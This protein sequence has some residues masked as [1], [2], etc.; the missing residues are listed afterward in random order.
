MIRHRSLHTL[1]SCILFLVAGIGSINLSYSSSLA[2]FEN[3]ASKTNADHR[4]VGKI[5]SAIDN[6]F[7]TVAELENAIET[8]NYLLIGEKHDN[9]DHHRL[10]RL[11]VDFRLNRVRTTLP[12]AV[13]LEMLDRKQLDGVN[14]EQLANLQSSEKLKSQLAWRDKSWPWDNYGK[15]IRTV[16]NSGSSLVAGNIDRPS[17]YA[18]AKN[19]LQKLDDELRQASTTIPGMSAAMHSAV[20]QDVFDG[21]CQLMPKEKL[22]SMVMI[23]QLRDAYMAFKLSKSDHAILI[24]GNGHTRKDYGA[25]WHLKQRNRESEIVAIA[26]MEVQTKEYDPAKY[27]R[28]LDQKTTVY[29]YIWFTPKHSDE[30]KCDELKKHFKKKASG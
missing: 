5:W 17:L 24:A 21:H 18:A 23:Q 8:G 11:I 14:L 19:S 9:Q 13:V 26:L 12:S 15:V 16:I 30:D 10:E 27:T 4:L 25:G 7:V 3:W 22:N 29:D 6:R 1:R 2:K 28:P 20:L